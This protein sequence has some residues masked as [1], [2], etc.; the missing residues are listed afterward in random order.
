MPWFVASLEGTAA[1]GILAAS[2]TLVGLANMFVMGVA[3]VLSP[4]AAKAY[5]EGGTPAL[6]PVLVITAAVFASVLGAFAVLM[7]FFGG[8]LAVLVYGESYAVAGPVIAILACGLLAGGLHVTAGNGLWAID[9]PAA[10]FRADVCS[11]IATIGFSVVLIGP[12]GVI[13]AALATTL[14]ALVD[15]SIRGWILVHEMRQLA[16]KPHFLVPQNAE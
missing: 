1:T 12:Y 16:R 15:A 7:C 3:N 4:R 8:Q 6:K 14:G 9:R 11:L 13:G 2:S 10:N 5:A